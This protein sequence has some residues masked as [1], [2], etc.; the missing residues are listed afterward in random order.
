MIYEKLLLGAAA[1]VL[2]A[3]LVNPAMAVKGC[4][5]GKTGS[6]GCK[7]EIQACIASDCAELTRRAKAKCKRE[8]KRDVKRQCKESAGAFCASP[9]GAF[10]DN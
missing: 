6:K 7:N 1:A 9:S 10:L 2:A 8:C 3:G 5:P 4:A